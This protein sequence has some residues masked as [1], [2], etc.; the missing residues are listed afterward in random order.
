[1]AFGMTMRWVSLALT[2]LLLCGGGFGRSAAQPV[3]EAAMRAPAQAGPVAPNGA[4]PEEMRIAAVVNDEVISVYDVVSRMKMIMISSNLADTPEDRKKL[5]SQVLRSL[6]DEKLELEEAKREAVTATDD[7]IKHA[8][9]QIEKQNNM[10]PGQLNEFLKERGIDRTT[11]VDQITASIEW[12]KLVRRKAAET[13]DI[14]DEDIDKAMKRLKDDASQP[15]ERVAEIF[16]SVDTPGQDEQVREVA[17]KLT[18]QMRAGARFSA[19]ARQF[20][21]SATAAV[22][23]DLGWLRPGELPPELRQAAAQMKVGELSPPI[24]TPGGYYLLL[25]LDR[26]SANGGDEANPVY[27]IVQ[28]VFPLAPNAGD[29]AK[30]QA[31]EQAASVR[32]GATDCPT[33]LKIGKQRAPQL[34]SEGRL[35]A[36]NIAPQ[37]RDLLD[38]LKIGEVS[39]PIL[40]RNGV[41]V[42]MVCSRGAE[43]AAAPTRLQVGDTLLEQRLDAVARQ[44]LDDLRRQAYVDVRA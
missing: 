7:E 1:M 6:I 14:T 2:A 24:R 19:I 12:A 44:Y 40:Q 33:L 36:N 30:R 31:V 41:G 43:K 26:R 25:V 32:A 3:R 15:E 28:V 4:A 21:Q 16:L 39:Q 17:E 37:M 18:Q 13:V 20:S 35:H 22:G 11:M 23:G 10:Q 38:R 42:I 27:D 9:A 34:S 5:A 29:A 8:I